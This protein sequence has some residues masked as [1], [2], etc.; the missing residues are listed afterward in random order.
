[1]KKGF[2]KKALLI[3]FLLPV[4]LHSASNT[5]SS[6]SAFLKINVGA[7][8]SAMGGA[9]AGLA[10]DNEAVLLNPAG[11]AFLNVSELSGGHII[12]FLDMAIEH[13]QFTLPLS[14][15]LTLGL[16]GIYMNNGVFDAYTSGAAAAGTFT[17]YDASA[18]ISLGIK[19]ADYISAGITVKYITNYIENYFSVSYAADAGFIFRELLPGVSF[20]A[21][22]LN[23]GTPVKLGSLEE[24]LP[25]SCRAGFAFSLSPETVIT[26]DGFTHPREGDYNI[27]L[28][29]EHYLQEKIVCVRAGYLIPFNTK[30]A[31]F[32]AGL[33][34]GVGL[35]ITPLSLDY[36]LVPNSDLGYLHRVSLAY[37]FGSKEI[38]ADAFKFKLNT[39]K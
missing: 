20:G 32:T 29:V 30:T 25:L 21:A 18:G 10:D 33:S 24:P 23:F 5:G 16:G 1:M 26:A 11:L 28:G 35:R 7:R 36:A 34:A 2:M 19:I 17:A 15:G 38:K 4:L 31:D 37:A 6:A 14:S 22:L 13:V 27:S 3:L 12:W 8:S 39:V 9:F